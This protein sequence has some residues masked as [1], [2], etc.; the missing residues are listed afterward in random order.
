MAQDEALAARQC[1]E[2]VVNFTTAFD[3][4]DVEAMVA[5]FAPDGVWA[6]RDGE[7][8]GAAALRAFMSTRNPDMLVRH[9]LGNMRTT[10]VSRDVAIVRSYVT[11]F[12]HVGKL[13][14]GQPAPLTRPHVMG[15][16]TDQVAR[17]GGAWLITNRAVAV[18]F[19]G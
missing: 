3:N 7:I 2:T 9:V 11:A 5:A 14:V 16:Y 4:G 18:D 15:R 12:L 1:E 6:R 8:T 13:E 17:R 10:F 19:Q